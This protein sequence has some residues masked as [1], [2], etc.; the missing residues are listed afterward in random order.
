[1]RAGVE[2]TAVFR[3]GVG[4]GEVEAVGP[5]GFSRFLVW[6]TAWRERLM[7]S[8]EV[9]RSFIGKAF[10]FVE[11]VF[12]FGPWEDVVDK[13]I[14]CILLLGIMVNAFF[15]CAR[16]L[17]PLFAWR[18]W[19]LLQLLDGSAP[20]AP[21]LASPNPGSRIVAASKPLILCLAMSDAL[22]PA[23]AWMLSW[24]GQ[25]V[26]IL[27]AAVTG[28]LVSM[29]LFAR[30]GRNPMRHTRVYRV[31]GWEMAGQ[32]AFAVSVLGLTHTRETGPIVFFSI[33]Q[34]GIS[35]GGFVVAGYHQFNWGKLASVDMDGLQLLG[36]I[37]VVLT[38]GDI[39]FPNSTTLWALGVKSG[40]S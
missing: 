16:V 7:P 3:R 19:V 8:P 21:R 31:S 15:F 25:I 26:L 33:C 13:L 37:H 4:S 32:V 40:D 11:W 12:I 34:F 17:V 10:K 5:S 14:G 22:S 39:F 29:A 28:L 38:V 23:G 18:S 24:T 36:I 9:P 27:V 2:S 20:Q 35:F 6:L 30:W 1:M